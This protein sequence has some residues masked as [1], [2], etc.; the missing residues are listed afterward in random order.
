MWDPFATTVISA[1]LSKH[2]SVKRPSLL[3]RL[4]LQLRLQV[5]LIITAVGGLCA[6]C[7]VSWQACISFAQAPAKLSMLHACSAS[8]LHMALLS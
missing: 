3:L 7:T 4:L 6:V 2:I 1:R 8:V 5:H